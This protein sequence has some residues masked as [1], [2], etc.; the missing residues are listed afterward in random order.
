MKDKFEILEINKRKKENF[1][2]WIH[3]RITYYEGGWNNFWINQFEYKEMLRK[4]FFFVN[5]LEDFLK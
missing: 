4:K 2:E 5:K 1:S 3:I